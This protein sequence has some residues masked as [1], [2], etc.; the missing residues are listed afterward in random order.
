MMST[1]TEAAVQSPP[2]REHELAKVLLESASSISGN[3]LF[4]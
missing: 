2:Q 1:S 4:M 3:L